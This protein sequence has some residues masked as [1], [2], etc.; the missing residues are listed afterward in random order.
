MTDGTVLVTGG[1]GYIGSHTCGVLL[2]ARPRVESMKTA[3][4]HTSSSSSC[5]EGL[6]GT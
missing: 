5:G 2:E 1:A 4:R 6:Y 3:P